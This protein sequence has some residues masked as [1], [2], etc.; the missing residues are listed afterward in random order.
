M[1]FTQ[2]IQQKENRLKDLT[3]P[4]TPVDLWAKTQKKKSVKSKKRGAKSKWR[5]WGWKNIQ[6]NN[7]KKT[8][9]NLGGKNK[10]WIYRLKAQQPSNQIG[11]NKS[12][13]RCVISTL[14]KTKDK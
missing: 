8:F 11:T 13:P 10:T 7:G 4:Q 14:I 9:L 5:T 3:K 6:G 1:E 12:M 2:F